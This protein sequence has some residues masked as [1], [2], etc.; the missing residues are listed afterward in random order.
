LSVVELARMRAREGR[1]DDF[2][3][4]LGRALSVHE[5]EPTCTEIHFYRGVEDPDLFLLALTWTSVEAHEAWR[6][7]P[8]L[9]RWRQLLGDGDLLAERP[10]VLGHFQDLPR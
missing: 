3:P 2:A 1:G 4:V 8:G 9:E 10:S 6:G 7:S 5:A